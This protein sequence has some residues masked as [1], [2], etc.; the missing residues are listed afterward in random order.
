MIEIVG[1]SFIHIICNF[2]QG[3]C[4]R[5]G[6]LFYSGFDTCWA[7]CGSIYYEIK[8]KQAISI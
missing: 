8:K 3:H 4:Q 1:I 5:R 7:H 2:A 6:Y